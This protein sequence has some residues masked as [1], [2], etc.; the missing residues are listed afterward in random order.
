MEE[1]SLRRNPGGGTKVKESWRGKHGRGIMEEESWGRTHGLWAICGPRE[2]NW[3]NSFKTVLFFSKRATG[4]RL[5]WT[6]RG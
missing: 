6:R 1:E 2:E 3:G 4:D 5:T